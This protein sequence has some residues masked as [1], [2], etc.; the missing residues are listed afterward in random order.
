MISGLPV[1]PEQFG[2]CVLQAD[3]PL[4]ISINIL[5]PDGS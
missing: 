2:I 4:P 5:L 3:F 1:I